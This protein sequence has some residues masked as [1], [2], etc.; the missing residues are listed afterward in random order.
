M[1]GV[2]TS[3]GSLRFG[4]FK[5]DLHSGELWS[6]GSKI[7]LQPQ[8]FQIL[9]ILL[10]HPGELVTREEIRQKLWSSDTFVDFEHSLN[11]SIKK[12]REALGEEAGTPRYVE[13]LPRRGYR[14]IGHVEPVEKITDTEVGAG[15]VPA[16]LST[17]AVAPLGHPQE[18]ALIP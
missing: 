3:N 18:P 6:H 4:A 16:Q 10:E 17:D 14:F 7:H 2:A 5:V 15:L 1:A 11:T 9:S 8:P 12:L 13:T